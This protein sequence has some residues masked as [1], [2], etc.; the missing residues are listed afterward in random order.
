M[1]KEKL[2][3][4]L[5]LNLFQNIII[6]YYI[7]KHT[8][9][10]MS[11]VVTFQ[12]GCSIFFLNLL[13]EYPPAYGRIREAVSRGRRSVA[14]IGRRTPSFRWARLR[15]IK[16]N[17][18]ACMRVLCACS[19]ELWLSLGSWRI[20][21]STL[22]HINNMITRQLTLIKHHWYISSYIKQSRYLNDM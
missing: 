2:S 6:C 20:A 4:W 21:G 1:K 17:L 12:D 9:I 13:M 14:E 19:L 16:L 3:K 11:K 22:S 10:H 8:F 5:L 15:L 18:A 7:F